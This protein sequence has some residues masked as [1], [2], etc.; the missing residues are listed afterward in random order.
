MSN[1]P[2]TPNITSYYI[3]VEFPKA[4]ARHRHYNLKVFLQAIIKQMFQAIRLQKSIPDTLFQQI[5]T[6]SNRIF[7]EPPNISHYLKQAN[8][9]RK[10]TYHGIIM[11]NSDTS[12]LMTPATAGIDIQQ[13]TFENLEAIFLPLASEKL[14]PKKLQLI[15]YHTSDDYDYLYVK[16]PHD[17]DLLQDKTQ[18]IT[19]EFLRKRL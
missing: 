4:Y 11:I 5:P 14:L 18:A 2:N 8:Q 13:L 7:K 17:Q 12:L 19:N 3:S 10:S 16:I 1:K 15:R 9:G 6:L